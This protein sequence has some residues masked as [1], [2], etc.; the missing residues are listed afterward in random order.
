MDIFQRE[1]K[2]IG[3]ENYK[4]LARAKVAVFGLGGVG[5]YVVEGLA[6]AGV[7]ALELCDNDVIAPHN[8][9][10]QLYALHSTVGKKKVEV[11]L[12]RVKD[13][14]PNIAVSAHDCFF[15]KDSAKQFDFSFF[16]YVADCID[17]VTSKILLCEC[18]NRAGVKIISSMG[19]GN[20]L[21]CDFKVSDISKTKVCPLARV[22][23]RELVKRNIKNLK[24]VYSEEIPVLLSEENEERR[25]PSSIS[26]VPSSAGLLIA[27]EI[28]KDIINNT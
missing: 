22:M 17:T 14:N 3:E 23:R 7:G 19:T 24:C 1:I 15:D 16:T 4:K 26:Y 13:I 8:I 18:A 10:R 11:A 27:G 2:L 21:N 25:T 5:S 9:N 12:N 6:R 28:I 20:K